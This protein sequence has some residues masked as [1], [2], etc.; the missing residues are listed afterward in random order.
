METDKKIQ[1]AIR[2]EFHDAL[3]ITV[4]HRL[5]TIIDYDRILVL[6]SGK[7]VEFDTPYNLLEKG[8][9]F[10]RMVEDSGDA[11]MLKKLTKEAHEGKTVNVADLVDV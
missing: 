7:V 10:A 11:E 4:A 1:T 5:L 6:E 2:E 3:L 9:V 8:G